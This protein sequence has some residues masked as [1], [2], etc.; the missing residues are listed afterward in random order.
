LAIVAAF[1][2][3]LIFGFGLIIS[4]MVNP[5]KILNFLDFAGRWDPSLAF[6]MGG[7][8]IVAAIGF[9]L[10]R[11]RK[12]PLFAESFHLPQST[13]I[14]ARLLGGAAIFGIGWGLV[15]FCP[16]PALTAL[17]FGRS[18]AFLFVTAMIAGMVIFNRLETLAART[19]QHDSTAITSSD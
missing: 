19:A 8:V 10:V 17:G 16:G 1:A 11:E 15:G 12:A 14:D 2:S 9:R 13:R 5:G 7:A 6:V 3:G 4:Q 18:E